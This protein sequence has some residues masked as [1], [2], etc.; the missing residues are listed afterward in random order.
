ME[1]RTIECPCGQKHVLVIDTTYNVIMFR[2]KDGADLKKFAKEINRIKYIDFDLIYTCP[3]KS[4]RMQVTL[5]FPTTA[6][7]PFINA[8]IIEVK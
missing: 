6:K 2:P 4:I 5:Q 3:V 1:E 7:N 8:G